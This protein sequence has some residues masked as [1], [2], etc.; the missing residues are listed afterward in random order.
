[1]PVPPAMVAVLNG[2]VAAKLVSVVSSRPL[3]VLVLVLEERMAAEAE[4]VMS[5]RSPLLRQW[6]RQSGYWWNPA[7][8]RV[9]HS[10][11]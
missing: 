9:A 7:P 3:L 11:N 10:R 4:Q 8:G 2:F 5:S 6:Q 1:M